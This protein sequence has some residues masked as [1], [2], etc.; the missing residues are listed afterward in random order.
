MKYMAKYSPAYW[1]N[2]VKPIQKQ[3]QQTL[4]AEELCSIACKDNYSLS[5]NTQSQTNIIS[6]GF[7]K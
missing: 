3:S 7:L 4:F 6:K 2:N 1:D 5:E